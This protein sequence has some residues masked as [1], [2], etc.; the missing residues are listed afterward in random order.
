VKTLEKKLPLDVKSA[1]LEVK[2]T[3]EKLKIA[4][5]AYLNGKRW[6]LYNY[7]MYM[8]DSATTDELSA[9]FSQYAHTRNAYFQAIYNYNLSIANLSKLVGVELTNLRY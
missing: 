6:M 8:I 5:E 7:K 1:Y 9:G 3:K 2:T 4:E